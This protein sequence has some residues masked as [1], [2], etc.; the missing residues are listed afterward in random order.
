MEKDDKLFRVMPPL[1][2]NN[3]YIQNQ[4]IIIKFKEDIDLSVIQTTGIRLSRKSVHPSTSSGR[5][6]LLRLRKPRPLGM[7]IESYKASMKAYTH[8]V[9]H[10]ANILYFKRLRCFK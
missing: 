1:M 6:D 2:I 5:T 10:R 8:S 9:S 4:W 7:D 3:I